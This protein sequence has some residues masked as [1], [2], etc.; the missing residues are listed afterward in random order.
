MLVTA[1]AQYSDAAAQMGSVCLRLRSTHVG[2][3]FL[4]V[5]H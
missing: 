5:T 1:K 3:V 2:E 4:N